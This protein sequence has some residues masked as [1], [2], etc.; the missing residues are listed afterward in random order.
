MKTEKLVDEN[1]LVK[2]LRTCESTTE[3]LRNV[4]NSDEHRQ[5]DRN[6]GNREGLE[7]EEEEELS[8]QKWY[9]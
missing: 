3:L 6:I 7:E 9:L 2:N 4:L 5:D 8:N 1:H